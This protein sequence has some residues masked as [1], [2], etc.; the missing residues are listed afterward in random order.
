MLGDSYMDVGHVGPTIQM[1]ANATYRTYYLAGAA[2]A[3][4]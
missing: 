3:Y 4:E 2:L 1:D